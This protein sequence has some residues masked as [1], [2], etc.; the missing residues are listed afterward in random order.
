MKEENKK[1]SVSEIKNFQEEF[2]NKE[3]KLKET[4]AAVQKAISLIDLTKSERRTFTI[5]NKDRL[6]TFLRDPKANENNLR[7]LSQFLYRLS[8]PY[9]RLIHYNAGM[10]DLNA[11]TVIPLIPVNEE[12]DQQE[13]LDRYQAA[14]M[15]I[16][17]MNL[18]S[19]L[20][21]A[22]ITLWR[23]DTFYG[24]VYE[25]EESFYV[26]PLDG[27]YCKISSVNLDG[28]YNFAFDFTFFKQGN[29]EILLEYW[30]S[31]FTSK[32]NAYNSDQSLRWQELEPSRT[33]ALKNNIDDPTLSLPPFIS[34]FESIIDLIDLQALQSVKDDLK[35]YKLL[36][37]KIPMLKNAN[38]V[39]EF[40]V[41]LDTAVE[42]Y[43]K[44]VENLPDLVGACIS[45]LEIDAVDF[46]DPNSTKEVDAISQSLNNLFS[47]VGTSNVL[48]N[49]NSESSVG[50][51]ASIKS[52]AQLSASILRQIETWSNSYVREI[53]GDPMI[54]I[55]YIEINPYN[56]K[57]KREEIKENGTLGVP[58]KLQLAAVMGYTPLETHSMDFLENNVLKLHERW[59]PLS[60]S[61][62]QSQKGEG[63]AP[64]IDE[65]D[66]TEEGQKTRDKGKNDK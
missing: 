2:D 44:L 35:N 56:R 8:H 51:N 62:T 18:A 36:V 33:I 3:E 15:Q 43:N 4:F 66:L 53:V 63:G 52:D 6:R 21:K 29:N 10:V 5:F 40:A 54:K 34:M 26:K 58:M 14:L 13:V 12:P 57:E 49:P 28:T 30:D 39:D 32:Y 22:L 16:Q 47:L 23:E 50:L 27:K 38:D 61:Y 55:K 42:F 64:L 19:E 60:S 48:F 31:E 41:D 59:I 9:R 25:D 11:Y 37:N 45:P 65:E 1:A 17:K 7:S 20:D 46:N 24:Y